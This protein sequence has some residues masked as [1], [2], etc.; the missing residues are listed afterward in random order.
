[1]TQRTRIH[2]PTP[3]RPYVDGRPTVEVEER[4]S[5]EARARW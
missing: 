4:R 2:I 1:M 5:G 3:L